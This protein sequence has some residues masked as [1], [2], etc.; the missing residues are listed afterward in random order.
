[1]ISALL[2][3]IYAIL[4]A[5]QNDREFQLQALEMLIGGFRNYSAIAETA[6]HTQRVEESLL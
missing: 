2:D 6:N 4:L 1:V 3:I 5:D